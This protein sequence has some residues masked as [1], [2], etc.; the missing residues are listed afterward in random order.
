M[1]NADVKSPCISV[2]A[3]NDDDIC[4][5]CYRS[6]HEITEW[7][8]LDNTQKRSVLAEA[9]KRFKQLNKHILL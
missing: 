1:S 9:N 8:R 4:V 7:S 6:A 2:C 3:L 5:G